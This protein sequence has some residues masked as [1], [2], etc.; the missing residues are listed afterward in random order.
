MQT[1]VDGVLAV[2]VETNGATTTIVGCILILNLQLLGLNTPL[3]QQ[4]YAVHSQHQLATLLYIGQH[5]IFECQLFGIYGGGVATVV[6][7]HIGGANLVGQLVEVNNLDV[8][9]LALDNL[10]QSLNL[11]LNGVGRFDHHNI[12]LLV[13]RHKAQGYQ[14]RTHCYKKF[15]HRC[16][17][18]IM[19]FV[20]FFSLLC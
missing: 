13:A 19:I 15:L 14:C 6:D 16:L 17:V 4:P 18:L 2:A 9:A 5:Y 3:I 1:I 11:G 7:Y 10:T 8:A 20:C 12:C